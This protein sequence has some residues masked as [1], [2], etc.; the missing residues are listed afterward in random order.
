M[1]YCKARTLVL[2]AALASP[3]PGSVRATLW[4]KEPFPGGFSSAERK[5]AACRWVGL[6]AGSPAHGETAA[7][8]GCTGGQSWQGSRRQTDPCRGLAKSASHPTVSF[9]KLGCV[10]RAGLLGDS[11]VAGPCPSLNNPSRGCSPTVQVRGE[12]APWSPSGAHFCSSAG[13]LA[14]LLGTREPE[15]QSC[16][17]PGRGGLA[18]SVRT[19]GCSLPRP[20]GPRKGVGNQAGV[21]QAVP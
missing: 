20:R 6:L 7:P 1:H 10:G 18:S 19:M 21:S 2:R 16:A 4:S 9:P 11:G 5:P 8:A 3:A 12:G 13:G 15:G 17:P 14:P